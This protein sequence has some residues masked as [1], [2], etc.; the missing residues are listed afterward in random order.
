MPWWETT[1][2]SLREEFVKLASA[3]AVNRRELCQ[4]FGISAKTG[5]KWPA[6]YA[7]EG[8]ARLKDRSRRPHHS[9]TRAAPALEQ[10]VVKWRQESGNCW[11]GRKISHLLAKQGVAKPPAP[12]TVT[13]ILRRHG[14]MVAQAPARPAAV[15]RFE[16][17]APN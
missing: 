2:V 11:G 17:A 12:S 10:A 1:R 8:T 4:R 7:L 13:R 9:P 16:R 5:Y 15:G 3:K 6:R 14:L